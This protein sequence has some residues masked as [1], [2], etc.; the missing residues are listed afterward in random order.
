MKGIINSK[1]L[2]PSLKANNIKDARYGN[3]QYLSDIPPSSTT[4]SKLALKFINVPNKYKYTNYVEIDV[5]G[6]NVT[7]GREGVYVILNDSVLD[8]TDR[9]VSYGKVGN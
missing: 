2:N 5:T 3:G 7:K 9:I 8:L 6:L 1:Q 4:P